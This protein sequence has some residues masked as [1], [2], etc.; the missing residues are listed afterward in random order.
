MAQIKFIN[1]LHKCCIF[2]IKPVLLLLFFMLGAFAPQCQVNNSATPS[3]GDSNKLR[4]GTRLQDTLITFNGKIVDSVTNEPV[5]F[6]KITACTQPGSMI[7]VADAKGEFKVTSMRVKPGVL[8]SAVGYKQ[9]TYQLIAGQTN[10]LRLAFESNLLPNVT[11]TTQM[12]KNAGKILRRVEKNMEKNYG[13]PTFNQKLNVQ[14]LIRNY[15]TT[16]SK[17]AYLLTQHLDED[18]VSTL[19]RTLEHHSDTASYNP[20]F[21]NFIGSPDLSLWSV[22]NCFDFLRKGVVTGKKSKEYFDFKLLGHY[23]DENYGPVYRI[24]F[25]PHSADYKVFHDISQVNIQP[26]WG[27]WNRFNGEMLVSENDYAIVNVKY[28]QDVAVEIRKRGIAYLYHSPG[29]KADRVSKIVPYSETFN[30][31]YSY[32]KDTATGKYFI[33]S[34]KFNCYETGYQIE[35]NQSVQLYYQFNLNSLGVENVTLATK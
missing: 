13:N 33:Q 11:V 4:N 26:G 16:E 27:W 23:E 8:L 12:G 15:D 10:V 19:I 34:L 25:K 28:T 35:N 21:F 14:E 24:S 9:H 32:A 17:I 20:I 1:A 30:N 6:A 29:W 22:I 18:Q 7:I 2:I 5:P 31:E 3:A